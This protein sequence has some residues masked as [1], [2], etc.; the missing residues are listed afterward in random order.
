MGEREI[1][2]TMQAVEKAAER[3]VK[4][5]AFA[6]QTELVRA[7]PKDTGWSRANWIISVGQPYKGTDGSRQNVTTTAQAA[8]EARLLVYRRSQSP[9]IWIS[10]NVPYIRA[11]NQGHSK[12]AAAG[13]VERAILAGV[14]SVAR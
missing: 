10:N 7:N 14:R 13:F 6:I 3:Q 1:D 5:I 8:G 11:L 9:F 4:R 12:Q 2:R